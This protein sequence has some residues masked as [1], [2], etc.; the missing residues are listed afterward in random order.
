VG[1]DS[2]LAIF[3]EIHECFFRLV[4]GDNGT[5]WNRDGS[6]FSGTTRAIGSSTVSP[7]FSLIVVEVAE[8]EQGRQAMR[9]GHDDVATGASISAVWAS[10]RNKHLPAETA[11]AVSA[12]T[13]SYRDVCF[14]DKHNLSTFSSLLG[15]DE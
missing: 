6:I 4:I 14:I 10:T 5:N 8:V 9:C 2:R 11:D 12:T 1:D 13:G 3:D 7:V 15:H